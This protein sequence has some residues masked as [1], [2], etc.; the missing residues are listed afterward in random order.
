[1]N[2]NLKSYRI[3][4]GIKQIEVADYLK[5]SKQ[6]I[7]KWEMGR[8]LVPYSH[9]FALST[10]LRITESGLQSLLVQSLLDQCIESGDNRLL[11]NAKKSRVYDTDLIADALARFG[12][13]SR[14]PVEPRPPQTP[15]SVGPSPRELELREE[16]LSLRE[17][18]LR[19]RE[20][21]LLLR[22]A[23]SAANP[24]ERRSCSIVSKYPSAPRPE[25]KPNHEMR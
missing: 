20:E 17:E 2:A 15:E 7:N 10:C 11:V 3:S 8:A 14:F 9:W 1:M 21:N 6:T 24:G 5:V 25:H 4:Q 13:A 12:S 23:A 19:L 18:N 22:E 16:I